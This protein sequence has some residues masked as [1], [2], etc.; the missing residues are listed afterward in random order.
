[1][2]F[3]MI[4]SQRRFAACRIAVQGVVC[5]MV[6]EARHHLVI[7]SEQLW[8]NLL[9][10]AAVKARDGG[11]A[12][13]HILH[14]SDEKRSIIPARG[15]AKIA[16]QMFPGLVP[17]LHLTGSTSQEV[18]GTAY[19]LVEDQ[20][21]PSWSINCSGGT[22]TMFAGLVPLVRR[23]QVEA[24]YREVSGAWFRLAPMEAGDLQVIACEEWEA[25]R[26]ASLDVAVADLV[27]VQSEQ[28]A[29]ARWSHRTP[30]TMDVLEMVRQ[31]IENG[32][33]WR[34]LQNRF[35]QLSQK[36]SGL[37]FEDFFGGMLLSVGLENVAIQ[38]ELIDGGQVRQEFDLIVSTGRKLVVFDLKLTDGDDD[39]KIDQ[40]SRL[41]EDRRSL[42]G[43]GGDAVA[44][45][46][47]WLPNPAVEALAEAHRIQL[48]TSAHMGDLV[49]R[50]AKTVELSAPDSDSIAG[51]VHELFRNAVAE[52]KRLF[53]YPVLPK[54][55][56]SDTGIE[57]RVGW[58]SLQSYLTECTNA[59]FALKVVEMSGRF[60]V[61]GSKTACNC[62]DAKALQNQLR[63]C[64]HVAY[65]KS[66]KSSGNFLAMLAPVG[67]DPSRLKEWIRE[68][69]RRTRVSA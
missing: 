26:S 29:S 16:R 37:A 27:T 1:M 19:N 3:G 10:L 30:V 33:N 20:P 48:W 36:G 65:F 66:I 60:I 42:G 34:E 31:G 46:P 68:T 14:S 52:G 47:T 6:S 9:G 49:Q 63:G 54:T 15:I 17:A 28:P 13:L 69:Q 24:F 64:G 50:I 45:R 25:P 23:P 55:P 41:A 7:A 43:L 4:T 61:H 38:L 40:I 39:A 57:E 67:E 62:V 32:W 8:P 22:K 35:P 58:V 2:H 44:V 18:L 56:Q 59:G 5:T 12:S 51:K 53:S 11:V 21:A